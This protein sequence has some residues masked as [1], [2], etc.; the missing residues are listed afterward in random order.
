MGSATTGN[1]GSYVLST[2][3]TSATGG[4]AGDYTIASGS[5][6]DYS[7]SYVAQFA[8]YEIQTDSDSV[9]NRY[10][11]ASPGSPVTSAIQPSAATAAGNPRVVMA[12]N[13][14]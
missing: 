4:S 12:H 1:G 13:A 5:G 2:G 6:F 9:Q 11:G 10:W 7:G 8:S 3:G 14:T